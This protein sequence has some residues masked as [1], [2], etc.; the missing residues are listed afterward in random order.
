MNLDVLDLQN[1]AGRISLGRQNRS[2]ETKKHK[3]NNP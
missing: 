2:P 1:A 3:E